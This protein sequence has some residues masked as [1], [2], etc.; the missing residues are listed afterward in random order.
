MFLPKTI[1][2]FLTRIYGNNVGLLGS[3]TYG[4]VYNIGRGKVVKVIDLNN[5][6]KSFVLKEI[7]LQ[8]IF[9]QMM[10][11][12]V[13]YN[14]YQVK[15]KV[16]NLF[17]SKE[18]MFIE[19]EKIDGNLEQLF[20][21]TKFSDKT[22]NQIVSELIRMIEFYQQY[23][24]IHGDL[25]WENIGYKK[26]A[27]KIRLYLIDYGFSCCID[28]QLL[29]KKGSIIELVQLYRGHYNNLRNTPNS[30]KIIKNLQNLYGKVFNNDLDKKVFIGKSSLGESSLGEFLTNPNKLVRVY[31]KEYLPY[32]KRDIYRKELVIP[33]N[34]N[35]FIPQLIT[36][37]RLG[38]GRQE[39]DSEDEEVDEEDSDVEWNIN[40][41][42]LSDISTKFT[43]M[44]W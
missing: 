24:Y 6:D 26:V 23:N 9:S 43:Y 32:I 35:K 11:A 3:G 12:P 20:L 25:H 22:I 40:G 7:Y 29:K 42:P 21:T 36:L 33:T 18:Y 5:T 44:T 31:K 2:Q 34:L 41:V 39:E 17:I 1:E 37:E 27:D 28:P 8:Q 15:F 16:K 30:D 38:E 14:F 10:L 4:K 19:M 13:L